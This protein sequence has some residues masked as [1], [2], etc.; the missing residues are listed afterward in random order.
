MCNNE[1]GIDF[2]VGRCWMDDEMVRV[3]GDDWERKIGQSGLEIR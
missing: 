3:G 1:I 2:H